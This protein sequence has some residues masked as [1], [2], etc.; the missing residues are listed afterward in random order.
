MAIMYVLAILVGRI[1]VEKI[2]SATYHT[3][4]NKHGYVVADVG[5]AEDLSKIGRSWCSD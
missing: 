3:L 1:F 4:A 5:E 2:T